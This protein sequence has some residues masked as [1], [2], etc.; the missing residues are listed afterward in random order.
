MHLGTDVRRNLIFL[1]ELTCW[2][3]HI[4]VALYDKDVKGRQERRKEYGTHITKDT[5][6]SKLML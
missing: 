1:L 6:R 3:S 5:P 4:L 2:G